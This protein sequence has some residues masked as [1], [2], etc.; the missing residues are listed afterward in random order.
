MRLG[1]LGLGRI[2]S[3]HAETLSGLAAVDSLVV[4]DPVPALA[5]GIAERLGADVADTP[6]ALLASGV[7]GV[8]IAAATEAHPE[9]IQLSMAA[10]L[11]TFCEKPAA[12]TP[13]E[14][15]AFTE[16]VAGRRTSP[17]PAADAIEASWIAEAGTLSLCEHRPVRLDEVRP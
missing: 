10:G 14:L 5:T 6:E 1:L 7:D 8:V 2:G 3:F 9:L 17:C 16:V 12:G 4:C 13:A 11:P 15:A